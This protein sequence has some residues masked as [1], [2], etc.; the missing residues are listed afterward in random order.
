MSKSVLDDGQR[1]T[2]TRKPQ[3]SL[4]RNRNF[5]LL[6]AGSAVSLLG[7]EGAD[8]AYPLVILAITGSAGW[9]GLFGAIQLTSALAAGLPAGDL[10]DRYDCRRVLM[11]A[12]G[13]RL[14]VTAGVAA[15]L[16]IGALRLPYI[17]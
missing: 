12:E 14:M 7:L 15:G 8:I 17:L 2:E 6:W 9:A 4:R 16:A 11:L 1:V 10:L 13:L 5:H 3:A